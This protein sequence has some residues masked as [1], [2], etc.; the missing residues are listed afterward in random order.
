[1]ILGKDVKISSALAYASGTASRNGTTLDMMDWEGVLM[2]CTCAAIGA[3]AT[4]TIKAQSGD[5]SGLSDA[6]DLTGTSITMA[7]DDDDQLFV[8]D[9]HRPLERYVR[10]VV[11]KD[12]ANTCAESVVYVQYGGNKLPFDN[13]QTD[14]VTYEAH[15]TPAEGTA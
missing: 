1:M 8:I 4:Y 9:L 5:N 6:A 7:D 2:I 11:S 15:T 12:G 3:G 14:A 13:S 10:C